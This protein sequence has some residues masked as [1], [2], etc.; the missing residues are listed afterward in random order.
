MKISKN[1]LDI[2]K[3][4]EGFSYKAYLCP[5]KVPTI[6]WGF[7]YVGGKKVKDGDIIG[8][9]EANNEL[10]RQVEKY[11]NAVKESINN[12]KNINQNQFDA[13]VSLCYNIGTEAFKKSTLV[14]LLNINDYINAS[15][16]FNRWS[17]VK[18]TRSK[19]LVRRR[20]SE[21]NL[22][23]SFVDPI[24]NELPKNWKEDFLKL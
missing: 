11:E 22:F 9:E 8:R 20:I 17:L 19:G 18:G 7:T 6:G 1:G 2:I 24:V 10:I 15:R 21:R 16:Q 5:A 4:F 12:L 3:E 13:L 14:R 23:C